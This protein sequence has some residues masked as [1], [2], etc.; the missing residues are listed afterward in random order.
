MSFYIAKFKRYIPQ[1]IKV[2]ASFDGYSVI[3]CT[4]YSLLTDIQH[5]EITE[6]E[7]TVAWKFYGEARPYRSA[8][9]DVEGL[10]PD[11]D[12]L[13]KGKRKTKVYFTM[14]IYQSTV[15]LMKRI[16]KRNVQDI[17][18]EREDKTLESEILSFIDSLETIRDIS[19]HRERLLGTEMSKSQLKELFLWDD[20]T[21]SRIGRHQFTLGF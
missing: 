2:I 11:P 9:S 14:E 8:Y 19:Y 13:A 6:H 17:F 1:N 10:E 21:N 16:F 18:S 20:E 12:Q 7:A 15:L 3:E 4:D 5:E